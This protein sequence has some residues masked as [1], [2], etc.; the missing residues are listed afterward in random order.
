MKD[1]DPI[2]GNETGKYGMAMS[3]DRDWGR[4]IIGCV[5]LLCIAACAARLFW[6]AHHSHKTKHVA[7]EK[8]SG[9]KKHVLDSNQPQ[10]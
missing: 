1:V 5:A 10:S 4:M 9:H 7:A 3:N 8:H 2:R 6:P